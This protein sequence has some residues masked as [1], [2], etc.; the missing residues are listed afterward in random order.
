MDV[1]NNYSVLDFTNI[2]FIYDDIDEKDPLSVTAN[3][4]NE[5]VLVKLPPLPPPR[6]RRRRRRRA[7]R[8]SS[9]T[10]GHQPVTCVWTPAG[11]GKTSPYQ[12]GFIER[13]GHMYSFRIATW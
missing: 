1:G 5:L 4:P 13:M 2:S 6:R 9:L 11:C 12:W 8:S 3:N 10:S 7:P